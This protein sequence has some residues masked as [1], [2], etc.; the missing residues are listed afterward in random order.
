M[1]SPVVCVACEICVYSSKSMPFYTTRA[2][3]LLPSS[4]HVLATRPAPSSHTQQQTS[5]SDL[6]RTTTTT[7]HWRG[8]PTTAAPRPVAQAPT[9]TR[10][11]RA[12][13][14]TPQ[15]FGIGSPRGQCGASSSWGSP[16]I[17]W[18]RTRFW[19]R[20]L[21]VGGSYPPSKTSWCFS[22]AF[23]VSLIKPRERE[24]VRRLRVLSQGT[25][26]RTSIASS[27]T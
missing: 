6:R 17:T 12:S 11:R 4:R 21:S 14:L 13:S 8:G 18:L 10:R 1:V 2:H 23:E 9:S 7:P 16:R 25:K 3:A 5:R 20:S 24:R 15:P 22:Q 27:I 19:L 26:A